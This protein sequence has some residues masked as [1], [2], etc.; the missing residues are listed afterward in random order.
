M[1]TTKLL[2]AVLLFYGSLYFTPASAIQRVYLMAGQSNM[3]GTASTN[4]LPPAYRHTPNN[5]V[6][7]H[8]GQRRPLGRYGRFGPEVSFAHHMS[9]RFP[10]DQHVIIKYA[11]G[12]SN[13]QQWMPGNQ[14]YQNMLR[15]V[16]F[17]LKRRSSRVDAIFWMQGESDAVN[18]YR[19]AHYG[20]RLSQFIRSLR[21]DLR[22]PSSM[23]V[24]GQINPKGNGYP[25]VSQIQRKQQQV[26]ARVR[27]TRLV[28]S[29]GL[30]KSYDNV[31]Y[32]AQGQVELGRRFANAYAGRGTNIAQKLR[33]DIMS[34]LP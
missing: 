14:Y 12:G 20:N 22:S 1:K 30:G 24:I 21:R 31:H 28:S 5:V 17:S 26:N 16:R 34:L 18:K 10:N 23:F 32:S 29:Y 11:A 4:L 2:S 27:N 9:R 19:A 3:S 8:K 7:F 6:F 33:S 15:E 25:M 13:M